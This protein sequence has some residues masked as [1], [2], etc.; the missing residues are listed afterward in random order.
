MLEASLSLSICYVVYFLLL[1]TEKS[2]QFNRFF[3]LGAFLLS[4]IFP[5]ITFSS[6]VAV[7][8]WS[9]GGLVLSDL[10]VYASIHDEIEIYNVA[11]LFW[12][13][14]IYALGVGLFAL[15][16]IMQVLAIK[17]IKSEAVLDD[18][19]GH[20]V[21]LT[22]GTKTT[23][24]FLNSIYLDA[25]DILNESDKQQLLEHELTHLQQR[26]SID[27]LF[28]EIVKIA[29][30]F[31]PLIYLYQHTITTI[32]EYIAD[33]ATV[34]NTSQSSYINLLVHYT[35][36]NTSLRL[37]NHF[38]TRPRKITLSRK[39]QTLK[40]IEMMKKEER[41]M[42]RLKYLFPAF[43]L[44]AI[45]M[46]VSCE[47]SFEERSTV[48]GSETVKET[49]SNVD[50]MP[51]YAKGMNNLYR[52]ISQN[53]QYPQFARQKSIE[54]KVFLQFVINKE[55]TLRQIEVVKTSVHKS[56]MDEIVVVGYKADSSLPL[57]VKSASIRL[58]EEE[59]IRVLKS[60]PNNWTPGMKDGQKVDSRLVLPI[61]FK[62]D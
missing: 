50:D 44:A 51:A 12:F 56:S 26:H 14:I 48:P 47:R 27:I 1:R 2:Y 28:I 52:Y 9:D 22:T 61:T 60:L 13:S 5:L 23:F 30:W 10:E 59:A 58:L 16:F 35:L 54:G 17:K 37:G 40:R 24:T 15:R 34:K 41:K 45:F 6:N 7:N 4:F 20:A 8:I 3:L 62:L 55:G 18:Y 36:N 33:A 42:N 57:E 19:K 38:G 11:I 46:T 29:C 43:T 32:H 21:C 25:T 53:I 39:S 49:S 31:N